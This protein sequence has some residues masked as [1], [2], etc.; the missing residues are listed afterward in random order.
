MEPRYVSV[1]PATLKAD[2]PTPNAEAVAAYRKA[3]EAD[4]KAYYDA[5]INE[6]KRDKE[7]RVDR[8]LIRKP[9]D[10][11]DAAGIAKA[12]RKSNRSAARE[13]QSGGS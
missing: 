8:V 11:K 7:V 13:S 1:D 9:K 5:N 2:V 4:V 6:Y 10:K 12:K 3:N